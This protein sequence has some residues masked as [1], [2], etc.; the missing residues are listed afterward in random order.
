MKR[1]RSDC[2]DAIKQDSLRET[3]REE[4]HIIFKGN[5]SETKMDDSDEFSVFDFDYL[6]VLLSGKFEK[7]RR[8]G[9]QKEQIIIH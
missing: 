7:I 1:T 8:R 3:S 6:V 9:S 4:Q 2:S 5:Q